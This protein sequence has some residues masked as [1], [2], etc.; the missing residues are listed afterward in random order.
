MATGEHHGKMTGPEHKATFYLRVVKDGGSWTRTRHAFAILPHCSGATSDDSVMS[1]SHEFDAGECPSAL[2]LVGHGLKLGHRHVPGVGGLVTCQRSKIPETR[3]R[4]ALLGDSQP[5]P[6][7]LLALPGGALSDATADLVSRPVYAGCEIL[8]AGGLVPVGCDL[9]AL[10]AGLIA[11][12]GAVI[13]IRERLVSLAGAL[14][15]LGQRPLIAAG[16]R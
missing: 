10:R 9:I 13:G 11:L 3:D 2:L 12:R 15:A 16:K 7:A 6:G 8:I 14:I 4:V 1:A 5:L